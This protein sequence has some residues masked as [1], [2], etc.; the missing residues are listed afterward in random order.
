MAAVNEPVELDPAAVVEAARTYIDEITQPDEQAVA[1]EEIDRFVGGQQSIA[2]QGPLPTVEITREEL[3]ERAASAP[4]TPVT[5]VHRREQVEFK[6]PVKI[7]MDAGGDLEQA[8]TVLTIDDE[9]REMTVGDIVEE[10]TGDTETR[11]RVV[12]VATELEVR[13]IG[14]VAADPTIADDTLLTVIL[15]PY[16]LQTA[17]VAELFGPDKPQAEDA[18]FYIKTVEDDDKQGIWG[19]IQ[20]ALVDNFARGI[21]LQVGEDVDVYQVAI[22]ELA[23]EITP[24]NASSFLGKVIHGK[25]SASYVYN[26]ANGRMGENPD[27]VHPGQEILIIRFTSS[28]LVEIYR[29]FADALRAG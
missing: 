15:E 27:I 9:V 14:E 24:A 16:S 20:R 3:A 29:Y 13:P 22:P 6:S 18:V 26:F 10:Y 5:L 12:T 17:T 25:S 21:A 28:E 11:L 2:L 23:D 7:V 19:I 8:V 4:E 1:V